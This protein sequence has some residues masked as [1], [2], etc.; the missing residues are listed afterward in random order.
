MSRRRSL[1]VPTLPTR[2]I[3]AAVF[4][5]LALV[6]GFGLMPVGT[7]ARAPQPR[8][9]ADVNGNGVIVQKCQ[10]FTDLASAHAAA[11]H[12]A[13]MG[14][15]LAQG[16]GTSTPLRCGF[17]FQLPMQ[18]PIALQSAYQTALTVTANGGQRV[19]QMA[20]Y[21]SVVALQHPDIAVI[22][23]GTNDERENTSISVTQSN[24]DAILQMV[25]AA[26][27]TALVHPI[28]ACLSVWP[29]PGFDDPNL[30]NSYNSV[31]QSECQKFNGIYVDITP[32][33]ATKNTT[34]FATSAQNWHPNDLGALLIARQIATTL[35]TYH[36]LD[37]LIGGSQG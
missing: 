20:Q 2:L 5:L 24:Y 23:L 9:T 15:S 25:S 17:A 22:E 32:I 18:F 28:V 31:I 34:N 8:P 1:L 33:Y 4:V 11:L 29:S 26:A 30:L 10:P 12:V 14:D 16:Y 21:A 27:G 7:L 6:I 36:R 35:T 37:S 19:D 13:I 3:I